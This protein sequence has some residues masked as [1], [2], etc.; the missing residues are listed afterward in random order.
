MRIVTISGPVGAGKSTAASTLCRKFGGL[1]VRTQD[2]MRQRASDY[3]I[4]LPAERRALQDYG[5]ELDEQT[6]GGWVAEGVTAAIGDQTDP[7]TL[8]V[9]DAVRIHEQVERLREAF[10]P[11]ITHVHLD[12]SRDTLRSRY[13]ERGTSSG[14]AE[15]ASYD[16][17][18]V[19][20]TEK[21]VGKL[22]DDADIAI[23]TDRSSEADVVTRVGAALGLFGSRAAQLVDVLVGGQYG[24]EGKGNIAFYL[25]PEYDVLLRVGGPNAGH[26]VPLPT[27]YT[28]VQ[29]PSGAFANSAALLVIGPGAT[30]DVQQV[31]H[32]A[33]DVGVEA[34]RLAIDPHAMVIEAE[35]VATETGLVSGI[36]S[37]GRGGGAAAARRITGRYPSEGSVPVRLAKDA[38]ELAAFIRPTAEVLEHAFRAGQRI[39]L[40]GT[41]GT[42]L[43]LYHGFYPH[44]TSRDTTTSGCLAESGIAPGRVRKVIMVCRTYPIRVQDPPGGTSGP[45]S[46]ELKWEEIARRSGLPSGEL[47]AHEKGS[48]SGK[49]RR[50]AEFDWE[51]LRRA[52]ELN[53]ATDIALTFTDYL[54]ATNRGARRYDQLTGDTIM[55]VEEVERVSGVPVSLITTC[56]D[57][58]G[59]IDRRRW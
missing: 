26:K 1:Y 20:R 3:G 9:V 59:V 27:P 6:G 51:L 19:N 44:V 32:E 4:A 12:A 43:S 38:N 30:I 28:H 22:H 47:I 31:L 56:F 34:E 42:A 58:R 11:I 25:G 45:M 18:A 15:L 50:V 54:H 36:G 40:E 7:P 13:A 21:G 49:Q 8:V 55:F 35:D 46:Q 23:D 39:L 5:Q 33:A 16:E 2:L 37:T 17:V 41:Q 14:L 10:G 48:R 57:V 52:A 24:S 53:G 29:L